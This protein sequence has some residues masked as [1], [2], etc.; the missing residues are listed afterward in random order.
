LAGPNRLEAGRRLS[1]LRK[2]GQRLLNPLV[3]ILL[4]AAAISGFTGDVASFVIIASAIAISL[5]LDIVQEHR[6]ELAADALRQS[7]AIHADV[8]RDGA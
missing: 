2:L 7:V 1:I 8:V 6:A 3:A 5:A 4:F